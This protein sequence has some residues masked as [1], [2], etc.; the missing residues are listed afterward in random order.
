MNSTALRKIIDSCDL[1]E[2]GIIET[3]PPHSAG[4]YDGCGNPITVDIPCPQCSE[5]RKQLGVD[6]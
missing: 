4:A 5:A 6:E 1:C 2:D 3:Y